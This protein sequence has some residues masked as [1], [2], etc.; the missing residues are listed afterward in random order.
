MALWQ[1]FLDEEVLPMI[2]V[3]MATEDGQVLILMLRRGR[4]VH[5]P[6]R[7]RPTF[8]MSR[9]PPFLA[10]PAFGPG[11]EL[12]LTVCGIFSTFSDDH[13][14]LCVCAPATRENTTPDGTG[15]CGR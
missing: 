3:D 13:D 7:I 2:D 10:R 6:G 4:V 14:R 1:W 8:T 11:H 15:P 5:V 9:S 12:V